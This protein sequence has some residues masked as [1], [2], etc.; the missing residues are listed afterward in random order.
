MLCKKE[1]HENSYTHHTYR[2]MIEDVSFTIGD[3]VFDNLV[4]NFLE[5]NNK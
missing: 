4:S 1:S 3:I 5:M 2:L